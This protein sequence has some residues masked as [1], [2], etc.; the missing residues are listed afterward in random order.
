MPRKALAD[1]LVQ[2]GRLADAAVNPSAFVDAVTAIIQAGKRLM[3]TNGIIYK[4]LDEWW[5]QDL[6]APED[7]VSVDHWSRSSTRRSITSSRT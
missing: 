4:P 2:S 7:H 3:M 6:F 1:I 5:A